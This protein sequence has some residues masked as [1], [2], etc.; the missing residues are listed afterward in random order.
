MRKPL[1]ILSPQYLF[2]YLCDRTIVTNFDLWFQVSKSLWWM[3][4]KNFRH[5]AHNQPNII[6]ASEIETIRGTC[7]CGSNIFI[8]LHLPRA[9]LA[10]TL[11]WYKVCQYFVTLLIRSL[12]FWCR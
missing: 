12:V 11:S 10:F 5:F 4:L 2:K 7:I 6:L 3:P 9:S 1:L 8:R